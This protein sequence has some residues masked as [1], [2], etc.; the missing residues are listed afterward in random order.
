MKTKTL[1]SAVITAFVF[2]VSLV[3]QPPGKD[4]N[5]KQTYDVQ[6]YTIRSSFDRGKKE[7]YGDTT[8]TLKPLAAGFSNVEFDAVDLRFKTVVLETSNAPLKHTVAAGKIVIALDKSYGPADTIAVRMTYTTIRPKKGVY[9]VEPL[10]EAGREVRSAQIWTQGEP[11]EH[12]HW[13]P[14][15]DFP[16]DKATTEQ[17]I[18]A[19]KDFTVIANGE[20]INKTDNA[21]GTVT[22]HYKMPV[23]HSTYLVS[24]A[25]GKY[26]KVEGKYKE[27]PLGYY[28]YPGR[29]E[30]VPKAYGNTPE[31][32]RIFEEIT[33]VAFPYNKYDQTTVAA[34]NFGGMENITATTMADTEIFAAAFPFMQGPIEDL[35]SHE[36]GHSWF[37][38]LV[39]CK[40]W[41]E[42]WLNEGFATYMEAAYRE[43]KYD[44][45]DYMRKVV[46]DAN[47]FMLEDAV[48]PNNHALY[49]QN[50]NNVS[51]LFDRSG[52]T[53]SKGGAVIHTLREQVGDEAF[54]KA[55]N[56]YLNRHKFA[57]VESTDLRKAMEESSSQDLG[58][59]FDQWVYGT[60]HPKL[61]VAQA[62]NAAKKTL[63]LTVN[64]TQK[65]G[66]SNT[67]AY[68][69]PMEVEIKT[70][71]ESQFKPMDVNKRVQVFTFKL[72]AK[73]TSAI[74]DPHMKIPIKSVKMLP[75]R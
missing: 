9:F 10:I 74:V 8:V 51:A 68:K 31:M 66:G 44:R 18:T 25:M 27:I 5:R 15:F 58:W 22:W 33:G 23:P 50:A 57:N 70:R 55:I 65:I 19:E 61:S 2:T 36:L 42:L 69:L 20:L 41:A 14:S 38:D 7:V 73:P 67:A 35:V 64:Q 21:N 13:F 34:F 39:T 30:I 37:G 46:E 24:F 26:A 48:V 11:D 72:A 59:F 40:N 12:R 29:E 32:M 45:K 3:A 56:T 16:S 54:W 63:T 17:I 6:H 1:F 28:I 62:W 75:L 60:G 71:G 49:N 43:K 47:E 52:V 53:Y 4:F